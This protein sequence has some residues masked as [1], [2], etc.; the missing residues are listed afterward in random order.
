MSS[1]SNFIRA[2]FPRGAI[3]IPKE[4]SD[5]EKFIDG[6]GASVS[7][8]F[9]YLGDLAKTRDP[10]TTAILTDLEKEYG[11]VVN[12]ALDSAERRDALEAVA[13]AAK[14]DGTPE[15]L[16]SQLRRAGFSDAYVYQNDPAI[17]P[18]IYLEGDY[19][20][21]CGGSSAIAG[22]D[23]AFCGWNDGSGG[24]LI[25]NGD[26]S[27]GS[28]PNYLAQCGGDA[29]F[30]GNS[31]AVCG[32]FLT[33]TI[34]YAGGYAVPPTSDLWHLI[35]FVGGAKGGLLYG[36]IEFDDADMEETG[37]AS[38]TAGNN[39]T[40]TK[41]ATVFK[42]G[43]QSL[44]IAAS[45]T[46][47]YTLQDVGV[48]DPFEDLVVSVLM[49]DEVRDRSVN[50]STASTINSPTVS[51]DRDTL[52]FNGTN[53]YV[54]SVDVPAANE[55][56][57]SAWVDA[58]DPFDGGDWF[59]LPL[60]ESGHSLLDD[61]YTVN[62]ID[63]SA[64]LRYEGNDATTSDWTASAGDDLA[65]AST[66]TDA[67][68]DWPSPG[69]GDTSVRLRSGKYYQSGNN[70]N[71]AITTEDFIFE[72]V[73]SAHNPDAGTGEIFGKRISQPGYS[74]QLSLGN[75]VFYIRD[76]V[77]NVTV[78]V[79]LTNPQ[80]KWAHVMLFADRD[81]ASTNGCHVYINGLLA[82][83]SN[84]STVSGSL[85]SGSTVFTVGAS[86]TS[87]IRYNGAYDFLQ[88]A[89][90]AS[91]FAGG[92]TNATQW[93]AVAKER[94]AKY[95]GV[96]PTVAE[97]DATPTSYSRATTAYLDKYEGGERKLLPMTDYWP[98]VCSR[99][100]KDSDTFIGY[101]SEVASTNLL[102]QSEDFSTTWTPAFATIST[103]QA[104]APDQET[105]MDGLI[106]DAI[107]A[108]H[109][110][111]QT[112]TTGGA[113]STYHSVFAKKGGK[114]WMR[115]RASTAST[116]PSV[117]FD[118]D[119]G[120]VGTVSNTPLDYGIEDWGNGIYRCWIK[121]TSHA[122]SETVLIYSAPSDGST[123]Y[124][125][126]GSTIEIYLW[127][128]MSEELSFGGP[129]S[130]IKTT[131]ASFTR[132]KDGLEYKAEDN[133]GGEDRAQGNV[134]LRAL[135][136]DETVGGTDS[137]YLFSI[138]DSAGRAA[139][140]MELFVYGQNPKAE[141]AASGGNA[142]TV[143]DSD[144]VRDNDTHGYS[145][146]WR[147]DDLVLATDNTIGGN[148]ITVDPADDIKEMRIGARQSDTAQPNGLINNVRVHQC[149]YNAPSPIFAH[150]TAQE[151][152]FGL[153]P[154]T[155]TDGAL[156]AARVNSAPVGAYVLDAIATTPISGESLA[157]C[158]WDG[159]TVNL[160]GG[161]TLV[162]TGSQGG[163]PAASGLGR[164]A[165]AAIGSNTVYYKGSVTDFRVFDKAVDTAW[166]A[167]IVSRGIE[168]RPTSIVSRF[169]SLIGSPYIVDFYGNATGATPYSGVAETWTEVGK[170]LLF[171]TS[172]TTYV[173]VGDDTAFNT[174]ATT[175][176]FWIKPS[177]GVTSEQG[178]V[179]YGDALV[180][181]QRW[182]T[183]N[184]GVLYW[185]VTASDNSQYGLTAPVEAGRLSH[186][187]AICFDDGADLKME[188][189]VDKVLI[190]SRTVA[191]KNLAQTSENLYFGAKYDTVE[192]QGFDG[193]MTDIRLYGGRLLQAE[194][195]AYYDAA[196]LAMLNGCY[197]TQSFTAT[198]AETS[199]DGYMWGD[200]EGLTADWAS[201]P[202]IL[203]QETAGGDWRALFVG[204]K[205]TS[206]QAFDVAAPN[207]IN[208][209]RFYAKFAETGYVNLDDIDFVS[210]ESD[211]ISV[212]K[213]PNE[214]REVFIRTILRH[215]P[216][217]TW[218]AAVVNFV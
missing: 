9:S 198:T 129:T 127:G 203:Y 142:G 183:Y 195:E 184:G 27:I 189:W 126:D 152:L 77:V 99:P 137:S 49:N 64:M 216:L 185:T 178:V 106:A 170:G 211:R 61:S 107:G 78:T 14:G 141:T 134:S 58:G 202:T 15:F 182:L 41:D 20:C 54:N 6:L 180:N 91:W 28:T 124:T 199:G 86:G 23:A 165:R 63:Q 36:S 25:V 139:D 85:D 76:S 144:D 208:D 4:S 57:I 214:Q 128:A 80:D 39:A 136:P 59:R 56:S 83:S 175:V 53:Q 21:V 104:V 81:E 153:V 71:G 70:T 115:L 169:G 186:I 30:A 97:D 133:V 51:A 131:T 66:G 146:G 156:L 147:T 163:T 69:I 90:R 111:T 135:L 200:V 145:M 159:A 10:Q 92:A 26:L 149:G 181:N 31:T 68:P 138:C 114:D 120:V 29:S 72:F 16:Q 46:P 123:N 217:G 161:S 84:I 206:E 140:R 132:N 8:L 38:W 47:N 166:L 33:E 167:E 212:L 118:L 174:S 113:V 65:I 151:V 52:T 43:T 154:D 191:S 160:Y 194:I 179:C 164:I 110:I 50:Q 204:E 192:F 101:L 98:R 122:T 155:L 201:V 40:L 37:V 117:W 17:D 13:F 74:A 119:N 148:D 11:I 87:S 18:S 12:E 45:T 171:D 34:L 215:K 190:D 158:T 193:V 172:V 102:L 42:T 3:W 24:F 143:T 82:G 19:A 162:G 94:F 93:A 105:T 60:T 205:G 108:G 55:G 196:M 207:G 173:D 44:K 187:D 188:L 95:A 22:N 157:T 213:I 89:K 32:Y 177:I 88:I 209:L 103:D 79:P 112:Y 96:Y 75:L 168:T 130:Y 7:T 62:S 2:L 109:A 125:G 218:C 150:S 5:Y 210:P 176:S 121:V 1:F 100:D 197:A 48:N 35:F 116:D 73:V 67:D